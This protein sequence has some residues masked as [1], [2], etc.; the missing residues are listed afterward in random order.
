MTDDDELNLETKLEKLQGDLKI[1]W[2]LESTSKYKYKKDWKHLSA[3]HKEKCLQN[4]HI[5]ICEESNE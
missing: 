5:L 4:I 1:F 3:E 2:F